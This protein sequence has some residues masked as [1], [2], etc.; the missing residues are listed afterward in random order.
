MKMTLGQLVAQAME[1][2]G[3][4]G[5]QLA[6]ALDKPASYVSRLIHDEIK[7]VIPPGDLA[8]IERVLGIPQTAMLQALG[9]DVGGSEGVRYPE[10]SLQARALELVGVMKDAQLD[11]VVDFMEAS[12]ERQRDVGGGNSRSNSGPL[13]QEA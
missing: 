2:R 10:G 4:K 8:E 6:L 7:E 1:R 13:K 3:M 11:V 5:F 12:L 9:Y